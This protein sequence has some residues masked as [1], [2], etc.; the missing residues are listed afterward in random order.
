M[1]NLLALVMLSAFTLATPALAMDKAMD[2]GME[3]SGDKAANSQQNKMKECQAQA[4]EKKLEGKD[5]QAFVNDCLKAKPAKKESKIAM[6]NK[7]TA[8]LKGEERKKAQSE[9]M[10]GG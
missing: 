4:G 9:C 6:C 2:K 10:K 5:R 8:G 1:K 7:Q 3:K